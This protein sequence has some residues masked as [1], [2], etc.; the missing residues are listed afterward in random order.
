[1]TELFV[2]FFKLGLFTIGGG[3]AMIPI[4]RDIVTNQKHWFSDEEAVDI[5]SI[6]QTLPGVVAVNMATYVG[7]KRRGLLGSFVATTGII[8]PS[9]II[10]LLIA[11]GL[12]FIRENRILLGALGG[13]KAAA[14]GLILIAIW[15]IGKTV[16]KDAFSI[17]GGIISMILIIVL[18]VK[19]ALVVLI[20][21]C[22][23][24][25]RAM[26]TVKRADASGGEGGAE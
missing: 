12:N 16:L 4:L 20:F 18:H 6:C 15:S 2:T 24:I 23:G 1:M 14:V 13:L 17:I 21:L 7:F 8:M 22:A 5:L 25:I 11:N 26:I 3:V 19:V 10:I 9:F